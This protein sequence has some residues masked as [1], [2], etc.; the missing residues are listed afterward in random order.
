MNLASSVFERNSRQHTAVLRPARMAAADRAAIAAGTPGRELM[1]RAGGACTRVAVRQA[2]GIGGARFLVLAG[3]GNNGGDGFVVARR[4]REQRG[5][6]RCLF[7]G[8]P[9][10]IRG[11]AALHADL[12]RRSGVPLSVVDGQSALPPADVVVD[13]LFGTGFRGAL[14]GAAAAL[15]DRLSL[16]PES[17]RVVSV[18]M[19]SGVNG[20]TG[21][22]LG[23]VV[24]ANCT[25][26]VQALKP[27]LLLGEGA[28][29]AGEIHCVDIGIPLPERPDAWCA[30]LS[31]AVSA[32][33][34]RGVSAHKWQA[35]VLVIGGST[36]M[37]GAPQLAARAAFR[38]GAGLVTLA[39]AR[40]VSE[41]VQMGT[42]EVMTV[43]LPDDGSG[44]GPGA[45]Q[46]LR[47]RIPFARYGALA[48]GM[49][50]GRAGHLRA[51]VQSVL[52]ASPNPVVLD[53]DGLN[54]L[55]PDDLVAARAPLVLTPHVGELARLG[56]EIGDAADRL[57]KVQAAAQAWGSVLLAKGP[58]TIVAA[59]GAVPVFCTSGTSDLG[60]A[61]S[62][63]VL[64]GVIAAYIARGASL[65]DAAVAGACVHGRAGWRAA[66]RGE[67]RTREH[68]VGVGI[69][70]GFSPL[71]RAVFRPVAR[72]I[73]AGDVIEELGSAEM[74]LRECTG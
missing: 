63:D 69:R 29:R 18:D 45:D 34:L 42:P 12:M 19:P 26:A 3:P 71:S 24:R 4:L 74:Q 58:V 47:E 51:F 6:V 65:Q 44:I 1:E 61:G 73:V 55:R 48:L 50:L 41:I 5:A 52:A 7:V 36:G 57:E 70:P 35:A 67:S 62:G 20:R 38:A 60:T 22:V 43:A 39:T 21:E 28:E 46:F 10:E 14:T 11:D 68:S 16:L 49:G 37:T 23:P 32:V 53:A 31:T 17:V 56:C 40:V 30:D 64:S 15:V 25:V 2:G 8:D 13:A 33:P 27:G 59:P 9:H 66:T 72:W 54:A